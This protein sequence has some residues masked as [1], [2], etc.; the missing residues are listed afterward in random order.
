M[1]ECLSG[2]VK[3]S[4]GCFSTT[5]HPKYH[6]ATS[7][8]T[9]MPDQTISRTSESV[10]KSLA[11]VPNPRKSNTA[12]ATPVPEPICSMKRN[13]SCNLPPRRAL[14]FCQQWDTRKI[15]IKKLKKKK[16]Q[17]AE[18]M[19]TWRTLTTTFRACL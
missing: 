4:I 18:A 12:K 10:V 15:K 19:I 9:K 2:V 14:S 17:G 3:F 11:K 1:E 13:I 7:S 16:E 5:M 8:L 6:F